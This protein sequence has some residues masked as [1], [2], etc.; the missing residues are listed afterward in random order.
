MQHCR[1]ESLPKKTKKTDVVTVE[2]TAIPRVPVMGEAPLPD[3]YMR[4]KIDK[5]TLWSIGCTPQLPGTEVGS[6]AACSDFFLLLP[7]KPWTGL[8]PSLCLSILSPEHCHYKWRP[9][10]DLRYTD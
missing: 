8:D 3:L 1:S 7:R 4:S 9:T 10:C 5:G 6:K 2:A